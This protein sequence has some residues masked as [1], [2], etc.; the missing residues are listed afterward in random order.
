MHAWLVNYFYLLSWVSL[1]KEHHHDFLFL[2][3]ELQV[4][5]HE[6]CFKVKNGLEFVDVIICGR[7]LSRH[8]VL[9]YL[10]LFLLLQC[11]SG[12]V[13]VR[14]LVMYEGDLVSRKP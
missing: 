7:G 6:V 14:V 4:V 9:E 13:H 5:F 3:L 11:E 12:S 2:T 8:H 1:A 10:S